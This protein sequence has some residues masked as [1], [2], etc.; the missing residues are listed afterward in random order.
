MAKLDTR[1][2]CRVKVDQEE[3]SANVSS[4]R[5]E[6]YIDRHHEL[7]VC[8]KQGITA[9]DQEEFLDQSTFRGFLGK[10]ISVT[11]RSEGGVVD[12]ERAMEFVGVVTRVAMD[13]TVDEIN[14]ITLYAHS[15]T[16]ALD[17]GPKNSLNHEQQASDIVKGILGQY[18]ITIGNVEATG[19]TIE[20][21]VQYRETDFAFIMRLATGSGLFAY[22]DGQKFHAA[23]ASSN[24]SEELQWRQSLGLFSVGL[25]TVSADK[26]AQVWNSDTK[27]VLDSNYTGTPSGPAPS[28]LSSLAL[29]ASKTVYDEQGF[30]DI[31]KAADLSSLDSALK[32]SKDAAVGQMVKCRGESIVPCLSIGTCARVSGMDVLD[33]DYW[34]TSVVHVL[35][36][37]GQYHN[38]FECVPL[39]VAYPTIVYGKKKIT[40]IQAARVTDNKDP[41]EL[42]RVKVAFAWKSD[43]ESP[44]LRVVT[45]Y[46]G[47]ERGWY[48]IP[49]IDDEVMVGFEQGD[50]DRPFVIGSVYSPVDKPPADG[51]NQD[52]DIKMFQSRAGNIIRFTD[53]EGSEEITI[54]QG[55]GKNTVTLELGGPSIA[56]KSEGD[57]SIESTKGIT[58]K[59]ETITLETTSGDMTLKSGG[60]LA[61][62]ST[63]DYTIKGGMNL[64]AEGSVNCELKGG[65]QSKLEGG[66]MVEVK[67][68]M[69]KIN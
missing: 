64:K 6:Q 15:P 43:D 9:V 5:L 24:R 63:A 12:S 21:C 52:N 35:E 30:V 65:T 27:E 38:E 1:V 45:P 42:G 33:G 53:T 48:S 18:Q 60:K 39:D 34:L 61:S 7:Q 22:Y 17:G 25:G 8:I 16:I 36:E 19:K 31:H 41:D 2:E 68:A 11:I 10:A 4:V 46:A 23:K 14:Q 50:P 67:G 66:A 32:R 26:A 51:P 28:T 69:V 57:I 55:D 37:S 44:W 49:E 47:A 29:D 56:I 3:L 59:G 58:L 13:N 62:E 40:D 54:T 20:Y